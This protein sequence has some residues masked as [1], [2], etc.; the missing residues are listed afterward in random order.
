MEE[1]ILFKKDE[2]MWASETVMTL[3]QCFI[4]SM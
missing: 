3:E 1:G 4:V 2:V